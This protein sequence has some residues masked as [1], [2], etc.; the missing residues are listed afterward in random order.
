MLSHSSSARRRVAE[1]PQVL[2]VEADGVD[3]LATLE[4][5][6][7]IRAP[8]VWDPSG[9]GSVGTRGESQIIGVIDTGTNFDKPGI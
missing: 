8:Q 5:V 3:F 4:T 2:R 1:L 7:Q 9:P 6:P